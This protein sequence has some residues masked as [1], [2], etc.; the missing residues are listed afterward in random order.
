[1]M[2]WLLYWL[3]YGWSAILCRLGVHRWREAGAGPQHGYWCDRPGC[4]STYVEGRV[5]YHRR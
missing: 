4:A 2:A 1:M 3:L 5:R